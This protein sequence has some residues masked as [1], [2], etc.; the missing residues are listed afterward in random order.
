MHWPFDPSLTLSWPASHHWPLTWS[1]GQVWPQHPCWHPQPCVTH[2]G[3]CFPTFHYYVIGLAQW[4]H[5]HSAGPQVLFPRSIGAFFS[6]YITCWFV[7]CTTPRKAISLVH[8]L[9]LFVSEY[10][11]PVC[12]GLSGS[13]FTVL[14]IV[15]RVESNTLIIGH[16]DPAW[17]RG[18]SSKKTNFLE[19]TVDHHQMKQLSVFSSP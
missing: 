17:P 3:Q 9:S 1:N 16:S 12:S 4:G 11:L 18:S 8:A 14:E 6:D 19:G 13:P 5:R 10:V 15:S 2:K 7:P